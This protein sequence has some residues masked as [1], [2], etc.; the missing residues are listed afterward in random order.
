MKQIIKI[1]SFLLLV[2][3]IC[4]FYKA[5]ALLPTESQIAAA[6]HFFGDAYEQH[7]SF[8]KIGAFFFTVSILI[9]GIGSMSNEEEDR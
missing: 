3:A 9:F 1:F 7:R 4:Y 6:E 2:I 8:N 5:Y